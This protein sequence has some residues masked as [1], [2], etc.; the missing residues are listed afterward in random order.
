MPRRP[1]ADAF[2]RS[3]PT[4]SPGAPAAGQAP[5]PKAPPAK[6][7]GKMGL[8]GAPPTEAPPAAGGG[9]SPREQLSRLGFQIQVLASKLESLRDRAESLPEY[10]KLHALLAETQAKYREAEAA[11]KGRPA[12]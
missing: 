9:G 1:Q 7:T 8:K 11:V 2:K 5:A 10:E 12:G 4:P 3:S 6:G